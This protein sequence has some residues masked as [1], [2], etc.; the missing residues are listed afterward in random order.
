MGCSMRL[1]PSARIE[2]PEGVQRIT[3]DISI[4]NTIQINHRL[5][6]PSFSF[7]RR[8]VIGKPSVFPPLLDMGVHKFRLWCVNR[9][10]LLH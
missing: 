4:L 1:G 8:A 5:P 3:K 6:F 7:P 2:G 9:L 10:R